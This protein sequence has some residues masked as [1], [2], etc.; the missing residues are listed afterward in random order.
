METRKIF[1]DG[2]RF[3]VPVIDG[4]PLHLPF[5]GFENFGT[6]CGAG[7]LGDKIVPDNIFGAPMNVACY[8]HDVWGQFCEPYWHEF[9]QG[10]W[11]FFR[12]M[13]STAEYFFPPTERNQYKHARYHRICTYYEAVDGPM[14]KKLFERKKQSLG[15]YDIKWTLHA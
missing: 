6:Y 13:I 12:N 7:W 14:G 11:V 10:N 1:Y 15:Q 3:I 8:I 4:A 2:C 9:Y 5:N